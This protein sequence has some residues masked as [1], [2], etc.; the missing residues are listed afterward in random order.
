MVSSRSS[1]ITS[2]IITIIIFGSVGAVLYGTNQYEPSRVAVVVLEPGFG[3]KSYSDQLREGLELFSGDISVQYDEIVT[4]EAEVEDVLKG[5]AAQGIYELIVGLG[6]RIES[7][8]AA[9]AEEYTFQQFAIIGGEVDRANVASAMFAVEQAAYLAGI[10][11]ALQVSEDPYNGRIGILA[12]LET[13]NSVQRMI[14]GFMMGVQEANETY[15]LDIWV[16]D[17]VFLGGYNETEL[18][19]TYAQSWFQSPAEDISLIFAPVRAAI[20]GI[21]QALVAANETFSGTRRPMVIAAEGEQDYY[22]NPDPDVLSPGEWGSMI[23]TSVV[24]RTDLAVY[25]I[26][27]ATLWNEFPGGEVLQYNL[28]NGGVNL[29]DFGFATYVEDGP[30]EAV[31]EYRLEIIA[32]D[33]TVDV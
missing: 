3:D 17:P 9:A 24:P 25:Q 23:P 19:R 8:L 2:L 16:K 18:A 5:L 13:D 27:N 15:S 10:F 28:T 29:T 11:A 12:S 26:L 4:T 1:I 32:G 7:P 22:G 14:D 30:K 21:R 20:V 33:I 6:E 31:K